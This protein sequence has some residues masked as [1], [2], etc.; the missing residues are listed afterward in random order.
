MNTKEIAES[1]GISEEF[2]VNNIRDFV[3]ELEN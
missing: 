1:H 2:V 3:D